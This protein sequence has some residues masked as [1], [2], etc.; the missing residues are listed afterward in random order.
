MHTLCFLVLLL[1][2]L[3]LHA[4][5]ELL[6]PGDF[7]GEEVATPSGERWWALVEH[8]GVFRLEEQVVEVEVVHDP[9]VDLPEQKTGKAVRA[10]GAGEALLLVRGVDALRAGPVAGERTERTLL[11]PAE[12]RS[13]AGPGGC[14]LAATGVSTLESSGPAIRDYALWLECGAERQLL[15][16]LDHAGED[17]PAPIWAGDLDRDG[18]L[19]LVVD[20]SNHYAQAEWALFLSSAAAPGDLVGRM[21]SRAHGSC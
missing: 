13:L 8:G 7:H 1:T 16:K 18:K 21:A 5:P 4:E 11:G 17:Q 20:L 6:W 10:P 15:A 2:P 14:V 12:R 9:V 3:A 19:D